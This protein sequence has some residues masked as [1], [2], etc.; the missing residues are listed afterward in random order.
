MYIYIYIYLYICIF[1]NMY[2][3]NSARYAR[4]ISSTPLRFVVFSHNSYLTKLPK[5]VNEALSH[6]SFPA[7]FWSTQKMT[8]TVCYRYWY[9]WFF[10]VLFCSLQKM[11]TPSYL[12]WTVFHKN[13]LFDYI[14]ILLFFSYNL[15]ISRVWRTLIMQKWPITP[16]EDT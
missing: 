2:T 15:H 13:I 10:A 7:L 14:W 3:R 12:P 11:T 5:M 9:D 4:K 6:L 8:I 1:M 16:K